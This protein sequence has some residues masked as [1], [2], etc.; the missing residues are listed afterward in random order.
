[1]RVFFAFLVLGA[2]LTG[3]VIGPRPQLVLP[4]VAPTQARLVFYRTANSPYDGLIWTEVALNGIPVGDSGPGTVFY[5]D[6]PPG[7]YFITARS[8]QPYPNQFKTVVLEPGTTMFVRV[9]TKP[10]WGQTGLQWRQD[11]FVVSIIDPA[12]GEYETGPLMLTPG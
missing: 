7:T 12:I 11:T 8:G 2:V 9:E 1:M 3:C 10:Y 6:V 4:G 5:R